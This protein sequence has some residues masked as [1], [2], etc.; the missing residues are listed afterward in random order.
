[1]THTRTPRST[2]SRG[3]TL[4]ELLV[5]IGIIAL[6]I[7]ILLPSLNKARRSAR[8]VACASN[9]RSILQGMQIYVAQNKGYFP[10]G[11]NSSG[12]FLVKGTG[13]SDTNC[14]EVSTVFDWQ[15]PIALVTGTDFER[16][17]TLTQ[18]IDRFKK[19][20]AFPGFR[21]PEVGDEVLMVP[22]NNPNAGTLYLTSYDTAILF[23]C[24]SGGTAGLDG[25]QGNYTLPP[26]YAPKISSVKNAA[27]KIYIADGA[28]YSNHKGDGPDYDFNYLGKF[29]GPFS[30]IGAFS[31][32]SASWD[33][34]A[35]PGNPGGGR[36]S[37]IFAF[38]HGSTKAGA[39][40]DSFRFNAGFF[41]GHVEALGDLEGADPALWMPTGTSISGV[42]GEV[43]P[44]VSTA[45]LR[46]SSTYVA[47]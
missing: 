35:A 5:V 45:Y 43:Y 44:D 36:E 46:G 37:R 19:L 29:G 28:R 33:R 1:M 25:P 20:N 23:Q 12:A 32:F 31:S 10:G 7:S 39:S 8:T 16:G 13:F 17:G 6:L 47:P 42:T 26:G 18:R 3:F 9:L 14:P 38:R 11:A 40:A 27:K 41:D 21:C 30:D 34:A 2:R 24:Q 15:A 22:F 4:V